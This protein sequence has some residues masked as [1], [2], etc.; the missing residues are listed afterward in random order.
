M[1]YLSAG[2]LANFEKTQTPKSADLKQKRKFLDYLPRLARQS[3]GKERVP[4]S[5]CDNQNA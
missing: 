1:G 2:G 3:L 5:Y 4:L